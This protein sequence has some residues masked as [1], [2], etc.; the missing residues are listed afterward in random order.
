MRMLPKYVELLGASH[1]GYVQESIYSE[2]QGGMY[3]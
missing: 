1:P 3:L 2:Q